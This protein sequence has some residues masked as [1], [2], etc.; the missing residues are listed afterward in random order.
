MKKNALGEQLVQRTIHSID[1]LAGTA[2]GTGLALIT[3]PTGFGKTTNVPEGLA[4][5]I[6]A[7]PDSVS[8]VFAVTQTNNNL[9]E[10]LVRNI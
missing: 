8:K 9:C 6:A 7:N 2:E 3:L 10:L 4:R 5:K 1:Y